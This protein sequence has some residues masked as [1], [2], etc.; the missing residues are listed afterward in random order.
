M[1]PCRRACGLGIIIIKPCVRWLSFRIRL[2]MRL[3]SRQRVLALDVALANN[4]VRDTEA[5]SCPPE[6]RSGSDA[7]QTHPSPS[8]HASLAFS[9]ESTGRGLGPTSNVFCDT[10]HGCVLHTRGSFKRGGTR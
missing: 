6:P 4:Q 10:P 2:S 9:T 3:V 7:R 1:L 8:S 5:S